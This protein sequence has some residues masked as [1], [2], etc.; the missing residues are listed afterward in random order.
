MLSCFKRPIVIVSVCLMLMI[1]ILSSILISEL[2]KPVVYTVNLGKIL[3]AQMAMSQLQV[4][5]QI[6]TSDKNMLSATNSQLK[7]T[8][9]DIAGNHL[10]IVSPAV[11][12]GGHDMTDKV[13]QRLG[14]PTNVPER[15]PAISHIFPAKNPLSVMAKITKPASWKVP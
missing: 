6:K 3:N 5:P 4:S 9:H 13:L 12:Q 2:L 11:I 10:V 15:A 7:A 14:L 1:S 8:I